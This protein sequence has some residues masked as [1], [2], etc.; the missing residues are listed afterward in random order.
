M[1]DR[2]WQLDPSSSTP[3]HSQFEAL[4]KARIE[5]GEWRPGDRIP[6]ERDLMRLAGISRATVR[7]TL[8]SLVNQ[9]LLE[10]SYGRGT[11]VKRRPFEQPLETVYS[12]SEQLRAAGVELRDQ[13][14]E[15]RLKPAPPELAGHLAVEVGAPL[16]CIRRLRHIAG[17]PTMINVAY[18]PYALCPNLLDDPFEGSLYRALTSK[19]GLPIVTA[20]DVLEARQVSA[21]LA[22]LLEV[23]PRSPIMYVERLAWTLHGRPLHWGQNFIRS[24]RVRFR[25]TMH[26][27]NALELSAGV[28]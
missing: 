22:R 11:F 13:L 27:P 17:V 7:Q 5:A 4:I 14:L 12:F 8:A 24:D 10:K 26:H 3:L 23:P 16:I 25:S 1:L 21:A 2:E 6:S 20:T 15:R 18:I 28:R 19:Y 9:G